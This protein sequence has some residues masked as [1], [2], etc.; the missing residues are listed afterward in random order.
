MS[1]RAHVAGTLK[2]VLAGN[3]SNQFVDALVAGFRA[4]ASAWS[5]NLEHC[6]RDT[7]SRGRT[8][9]YHYKAAVSARLYNTA[10]ECQD[11]VRL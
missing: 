11:G 9:K 2:N 10:T 5:P 1:C 3:L 7:F 8:A 6:R 4:A